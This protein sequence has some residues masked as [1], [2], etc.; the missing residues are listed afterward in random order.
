M[1]N[2]LNQF[3]G[4][5]NQA[6]FVIWMRERREELDAQIIIDAEVIDCDQPAKPAQ[7]PHHCPDCA[8][9]IGQSETAPRAFTLNHGTPDEK[10]CI[11][12][13]AG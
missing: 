3:L 9:L 8:R 6:A 11:T 1:K 2:H 10:F 7:A 12:L 4:L 13:G 5:I